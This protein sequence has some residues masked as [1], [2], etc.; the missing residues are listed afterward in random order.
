MVE[1]AEGNSGGRWVGEQVCW[2]VRNGKVHGIIAM[3]SALR[4]RCDR[5][6]ALNFIE[7]LPRY[8]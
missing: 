1:V 6:K 3:P 2:D 7:G 4:S 8:D 5:L